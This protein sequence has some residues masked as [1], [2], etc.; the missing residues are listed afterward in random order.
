VIHEGLRQFIWREIAQAEPS[1]GSILRSCFSPAPNAECRRATP[2]L[3]WHRDKGGRTPPRR[4]SPPP[5][6]PATAP[7]A[8]TTQLVDSQRFPTAADEHHRGR[9]VAR[10]RLRICFSTGARWC[11]RFS[12]AFPGSVV[13][14]THPDFDRGLAAR[15]RRA[16]T[17]RRQRPQ[18]L[19][20]NGTLLPA[21]DRR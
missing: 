17:S 8:A 3:W 9:I 6:R 12:A 4:T 15:D 7:R 18:A 5:S 1:R 19:T 13:T 10:T 14:S 16:E 2:V 11:A 21:R 20:M